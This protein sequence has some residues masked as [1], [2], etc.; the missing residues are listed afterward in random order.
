MKLIFDI[1]KYFLSTLYSWAGKIRTVNISK[2]NILFAPVTH[3]EKA[4]TYFE[5]TL[6]KNLP[7]NE[8]NKKV[9]AEK[10]AIIHCEFNF[11]HPFREGNGRVIRLFL[12]LISVNQDY[13]MISF[14]KTTNKD[15]IN[16]C[17]AG[18]QQKYQPMS[19]IIYKGLIKKK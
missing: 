10:I 6:D 12:D 8:D 4:L 15:Y 18:M 16:A 9:L 3:I 7:K 17:I 13:D 19:D 11:I 5:T 2:N 1:H 14:G